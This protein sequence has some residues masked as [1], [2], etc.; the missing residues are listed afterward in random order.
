MSGEGGDNSRFDDKIISPSGYT[1]Q[2]STPTPYSILTECTNW[3]ILERYNLNPILYAE[4]MIHWRYR[5]TNMKYPNTPI[6][7]KTPLR[8]AA[9]F[10]L[11]A[12]LLT[13]CD[14]PFIPPS[15][16]EGEVKTEVK[17]KV[18]RT[19]DGSVITTT[20]D[21]K[22]NITGRALFISSSTTSIPDRAYFNRALTRISFPP[23]LSSIGKEAF[24]RNRL[25]SVTI[26]H[27]VKSLGESAFAD[28]DDIEEVTLSQDL[29]NSNPN[30]FPA[31]VTFKDDNGSIITPN[32]V[33]EKIT[34][35]DGSTIT[36][37]KTAEG[38]IISRALVISS[39]VTSINPEAY[40]NKG[41]TSVTIPPSVIS[42][43]ASALRDNNLTSVS[44]PIEVRSL[45]DFAFAGNSELTEVTLSQY[46]LNRARTNIF[47][48]GVIFKD[49]DGN[50]I[51]RNPVVEKITTADGSTITVTRNAEGRIFSK[52]L[53]VRSSL[54][55]IAD[56]AYRNMGLTS[57]TIPPDSQL[58]SIGASAFRDNSLTSVSIPVRVRSLGDFAFAGNSGLTEVTLSQA[59]FIDTNGNA[60]P[61]STAFKTHGGGEMEKLKDGSV[62][63]TQKSAYGNVMS[64][65]LYI[66]SSV[67]SIEDNAFEDKGLTSL[68]IPSSV[69]SIGASA[70][71]SNTFKQVLIPVSVTFLG[72]FAFADGITHTE[73]TLSQALLRASNRN[74]FPTYTA[75]KTHG[76][77]EMEKLRDGSVITTRKNSSGT[78]ID[79]ELY[80][81]SSVTSIGDHA[82]SD[83]NLTSVIIPSSVTSIGDSAFSDNNLTSLTIP[84]SVTSIGSFAFFDNNLTSVIIP[85]SVT[86][87]GY[88]AFANNSSLTEVILSQAL[89]LGTTGLFDTNSDPFP[90]SA[91]FKT[92]GGSEME[93]LADGSVITTT[94]RKN[95]SGTVIDKQLYIRSSVNEILDNAFRGANLTSVSIPSSVKYIGDEAFFDNNLTSV[96]IPSSVTSVGHRAFAGNSGLT[97]VI[98]TQAL[99]LDTSSDAFP[100]S[101]VFKTHGGGEMEKLADGSVITTLKNS[102]GT[103]IGRTLHISP[104]A[105]SIEDHAFKDKGLTSVTISHSV[106][107]IG[108]SAFSGNNLTSVTIPTTVTSLGDFAFA[109]NSGLTEVI[110]TQ[111]L[112][113]DTN[114]NAFPASAVFKTHGGGE[115]EKLADGS[116]IT[117]T[118]RKN[119]SGTVIDR[120]LHISPSAAFIEDHSFKD[121]GLTS[122]TIPASVTSIGR[123]AFSGNNLTS[124]TIPTSVTSLGD[125]A[126]AGNSGL[127][128]VILTQT[129]LLGTNDNAFPA[130]AVFK[131]HGGDEMEKL[132]NGSFITTQKDSSGTVISRTL[133]I[134]PS[135][136]FI[137]DHAFKDKGLTSVT[138]PASVTSIGRSA[139]SRNNLT[140]V[141]IPTSVTSLGDFAFAGNN[142]LTEVILTQ[143]LLNKTTTNAWPAGVI[144]KD[145]SGN[146]IK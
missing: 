97:E 83:D 80:I 103:V 24:A 138:I 41:L 112:L 53:T 82:F 76:G 114:D 140:S 43:G 85:S 15:P 88:Q 29:L 66:S 98:L 56:T 139:F 102:S 11:T 86:S 7:L 65:E 19:D 118:T 127:T 22:G 14:N 84:S 35:A 110:L 64:K 137:E 115:M 107:S 129:L 12:L 62:I 31:R 39:S 111:A 136:A 99:L 4:S 8:L 122:V 119:S 90:A 73:F 143:D 30:A 57:L 94:T 63:I 87:L 141:T 9:P 25:K 145:H 96:T 134:S 18:T 120:T 100:A 38:K 6:I 116:V 50:P 135:A 92:H 49:H 1:W 93:K 123:S 3:C 17:T 101:A 52:N 146:I 131:T 109:G 21:S 20:R 133:H 58:I 54:T 113:L 60:F 72:D 128:E 28:N 44:I 70:F 124:V 26:P 104:S 89:L 32:S 79:K 132:T 81:P 51:T 77:S 108:R 74:A 10:V 106:T 40:R 71:R 121:K 27:S 126:F 125:F 5:Y 45:A 91:A 130:S 34:T 36:T 144:F 23:S 61:E 117:T 55:S 95:S 105:A 68:T 69:T 2:G 75:F 16:A 48:P 42:I 13:S 47:P 78:V 67:T 46:L 142:G 37:T 33:V 59:L